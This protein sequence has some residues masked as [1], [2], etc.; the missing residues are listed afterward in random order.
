VILY[1]GEGRNIKGQIMKTVSVQ[2]A[3]KEC[4]SFVEE[5]LSPLGFELLPNRLPYYPNTYRK[6]NEGVALI[7]D[8]QPSRKQ[9]RY[10]INLGF[11][12]TL[13]PF[14]YEPE[15]HEVAYLPPAVGSCLAHGRLGTLREKQHYDEWYFVK[16]MPEFSKILKDNLVEAI[17]LLAQISQFFVSKEECLRILTP[18]VMDLELA[19]SMACRN[20]SETARDQL[21]A[22]V[23]TPRSLPSW[24]IR[25]EIDAHSL[26][27]F[28]MIVALRSGQTELARTYLE[29]MEKHVP[30]ERRPDDD[31]WFARVRATFNRLAGG[32]ERVPATA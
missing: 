31:V 20:A 28:L 12:P 7:L 25:W 10:S 16:E 19:R 11:H 26:V 27:E 22:A 30:I 9:D 32:Q 18:Q 5:F 1:F 17:T 8:I 2:N 14:F 23:A 21:D 3:L 24:L 4:E 29:L 6:V 15:F 13:L